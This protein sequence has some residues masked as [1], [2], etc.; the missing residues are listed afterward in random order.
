MKYP[1]KMKDNLPEWLVRAVDMQGGD[2][3][4]ES[5]VFEAPDG[6][7][8]VWIWK[9]DDEPVLGL[10]SRAVA[11]RVARALHD[12]YRSGGEGDYFYD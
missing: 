7:W 4:C 3:L 8:A 10:P 5:E 6:S 11:E 12:A 1:A 9:D 2:I